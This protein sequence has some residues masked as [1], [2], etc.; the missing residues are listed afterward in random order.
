MS[1]VLWYMY[2]WICLKNHCTFNINKKMIC[3]NNVHNLQHKTS[4][5]IFQKLV[6]Q[7]IAQHDISIIYINNA[8]VSISSQLWFNIGGNHVKPKNQFQGHGVIRI[9]P[10]EDRP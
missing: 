2:T 10:T 6:R 3:Q 7:A 8:I 1:N 4:S 5:T 9:C